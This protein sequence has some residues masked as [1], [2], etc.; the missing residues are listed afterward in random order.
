MGF[1]T[2]KQQQTTSS[3]VAPVAAT[4]QE[5]G[6]YILSPGEDI[7]EVRVGLAAKAKNS[8]HSFATLR[9]TSPCGAVLENGNT[10]QV[11][12]K[13]AISTF[14]Y[15]KAPGQ[16]KSTIMFETD[17]K[18]PEF[19]M[20]KTGLINGTLR[21]YKQPHLSPQ[22]MEVKTF[23]E[24]GNLVPIDPQSPQAEQMLAGRPEAIKAL[25]ELRNS[26][27]GETRIPLMSRGQWGEFRKLFFGGDYPVFYGNPEEG[28][29][30]AQ[31]LEGMEDE[32]KAHS[33][34]IGF[35]L[36]REGQPCWTER[37]EATLSTG[38]GKKPVCFPGTTTAVKTR[39]VNV[40]VAYLKIEG[41]YRT[42]DPANS[43]N[44]S[45]Y[46]D[47]MDQL[48]AF[49]APDAEGIGKEV[50][51][52][53]LDKWEELRNTL[54]GEAGGKK[55][56]KARKDWIRSLA[57]SSNPEDIETLRKS[58]KEIRSLAQEGVSPHWKPGGVDALEEE[59]KSL[60]PDAFEDEDEDESGVKPLNPDAFE[61]ESEPEPVVE[62]SRA[63]ILAKL[64][65]NG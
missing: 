17:E 57:V 19:G 33:M 23:L 62:T 46:E 5:T 18:S 53:R 29:D 60:N 28:D 27:S 12:L 22:A 15:G 63:A 52:A 14:V 58:L 16:T 8:P 4:S 38:K 21:R 34:V 10:K 61:S 49:S 31:E 1:Y 2:S 43:F 42:V 47:Q 44:A 20:P 32:L 26:G 9:G 48:E 54:R 7:L 59:V 36:K 24:S 30:L 39:P 11:F 50:I 41:Y 35:R 55:K 56:V 40:D 51:E 25:E 64:K 13:L 65:G 45:Y 6:E 37:D 3:N